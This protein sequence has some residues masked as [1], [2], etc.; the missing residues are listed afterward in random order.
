MP[1]QAAALIAGYLR[2]FCNLPVFVKELK[3]RFSRWYNKHHNRRGTLW[4]ERFKSVLVEDGEAL[5]TMA[6][7]TDLNPLRAGMVKDP[8]DY[9]NHFEPRR[10]SGARVLREDAQASLFSARQLTVRTVA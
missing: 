9:R 7:Y 4:M 5:R 6:A 2:R 1:E 10:T 8:K 3:E